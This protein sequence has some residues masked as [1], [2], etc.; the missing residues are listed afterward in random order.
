[1]KETRFGKALAEIGKIDGAESFVRCNGEFEGRALQ[2][3]DENFQIIGLDVGVLGRAAEKIFRMLDDKLIE[4]RG[5]GDENRAGSAAA[6]A[7]AARTLPGGGNRAGVASHHA[8][9]KRANINSQFQGASGDDAAD[10]PLAQAALD[11]AAFA[12]QIAAAIAANRL[13]PRRAAADWPAA[14]R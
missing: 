10:A 6:A 4:R 9:V 8:G 11:F 14:N 7:G 3:V 5:G 12:R 2:V 13:E 1:M